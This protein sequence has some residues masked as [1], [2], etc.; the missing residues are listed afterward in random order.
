MGDKSGDCSMTSLVPRGRLLAVFSL[1]A[2]AQRP[3]R[4]ARAHYEGKEGH[5]LSEFKTYM[6]EYLASVCDHQ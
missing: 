3:N 4:Y 2:K 5:N 1:M 6:Y